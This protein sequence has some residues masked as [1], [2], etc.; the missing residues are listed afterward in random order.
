MNLLVTGG[1]G[2]IGSNFIRYILEKYPNYKITNLDLLTYA[3]NLQNL[4]DIEKNNNYKFIKGDIADYKLV[5]KILIENKIEAVINFAAES[6]VDRSIQDPAPFI[7]TNVFGTQILLQVSKENNIKRYI[8][9][10]TDEVYG[11]AEPDEYFTENT[12]LRPNS[13]YSASKASA[14]LLVR[15]YWEHINSQLLLQDVQI[16]MAHINFQKN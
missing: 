6:H 3:G 2:F 5:I 14:D 10:S 12:P 7:T 16:T 8:Q 15:S 1:C 4:K 9:V 13:P 11:S